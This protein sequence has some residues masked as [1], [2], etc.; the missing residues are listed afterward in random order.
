MELIDG[1]TIERAWDALG[2]EERVSVCKELG[3]MVHEWRSLKQGEGEPFL[4]E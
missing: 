2:E 3:A 1:I 4:G